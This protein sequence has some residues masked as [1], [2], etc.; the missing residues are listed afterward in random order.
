[1]SSFYILKPLS[2]C[3][4]LP[5]AAAIHIVSL[6]LSVIV[7][8]LDHPEGQWHKHHSWIDCSG[9][10]ED[11]LCLIPY[12]LYSF[13]IRPSGS[14]RI[15]SLSSSLISGPSLEMIMPLYADHWAAKDH[16]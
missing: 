12:T 14:C 1:M 8:F 13:N 2:Y 16:Q 4:L 6:R 9:G 5:L 11:M 7:W 15:T 3:Y 10:L